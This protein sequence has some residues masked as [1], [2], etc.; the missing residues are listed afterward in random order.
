MKV[1]FEKEKFSTVKDFGHSNA[2]FYA[3][4]IVDGKRYG[5]TWKFND[6]K[7]VINQDFN[8]RIHSRENR[9][10]QI[11]GNT[12]AELKSNLYDAIHEI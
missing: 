4:C 3:Y 5:T 8:T 6:G 7:Y 2:K 12:L 9:P 10:K 11:V 1:K